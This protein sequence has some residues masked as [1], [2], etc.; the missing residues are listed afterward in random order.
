MTSGTAVHHL[1]SG[2][3]GVGV[4]M[5]CCI[6]ALRWTQPPLVLKTAK[7]PRSVV[8]RSH[9]RRLVAIASPATQNHRSNLCRELYR[10]PVAFT[11]ASS[12]VQDEPE[13][14]ESSDAVTG[15]CGHI[16]QTYADR[17]RSWP[18]WLGKEMGEA[19][20]CRERIFPLALQPRAASA[21]WL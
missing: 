9:N 14:V 18:G 16:L 1:L 11:Q 7:P 12:P 19:T 6:W 3:E 17:C 2:Q 4:H 10:G 5:E 21:P 13:G 20:G 15:T 8:R